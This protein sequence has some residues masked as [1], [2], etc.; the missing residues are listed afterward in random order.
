MAQATLIILRPL[1]TEMTVGRKHESSL[2]SYFSTVRKIRLLE[3][4]LLTLLQSA[5]LFGMF[6]G[7]MFGTCTYLA[8]SNLTQVEKLGSGTKSYRLAVLKPPAEKLQ[9]VNPS[10]DPLTAYHEIT[11]P[12]DYSQYPYPRIQ[13]SQ[14]SNQTNI[15]AAPYPSHTNQKSSDGST[16]S[17]K[18]D[19]LHGPSITENMTLGVSSSP[20]EYKVDS[21][22]RAEDYNAALPVQPA[23]I[24]DARQGADSDNARIHAKPVSARDMMA[25]RT[26]AILEMKTG[27]NPWDL[28]SPLLNIQTVMGT[29][30]IDYLLPIRRSPCCNHEDPESYYDLGPAVDR[31]KVSYNLL[32]AEDIRRS[33]RPGPSKPSVKASPLTP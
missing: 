3:T 26:F 15:P 24:V 7:S 10:T 31:V 29:S 20:P 8:I 9:L 33:G 13:T 2:C 16:T 21:T 4:R 12:L 32:N 22:P 28:G 14:A 6:T 5:G 1:L 19:T 25:T 23:S 11:Y 17:P 30:L 18:P 27:E